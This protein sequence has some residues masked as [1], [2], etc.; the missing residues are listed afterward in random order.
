[1]VSRYSTECGGICDLAQLAVHHVH[2]TVDQVGI[3]CWGILIHS[4][5]PNEV[6]ETRTVSVEEIRDEGLVISSQGLR[7]GV[8]PGHQNWL[9]PKEMGLH[10][11]HTTTGHL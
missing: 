9:P 3:T 8:D 11:H 4:T 10:V 5:L 7:Q 2:T 1:M 6:Q